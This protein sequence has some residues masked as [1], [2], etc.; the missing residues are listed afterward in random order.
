MQ[1]HNVLQYLF[2]MTYYNWNPLYTIGL[3]S[4]SLGT[5]TSIILLKVCGKN[6]ENNEN[7]VRFLSIEHN[8]GS[9][10]SILTEFKEESR[11]D[12]GQMKFILNLQTEENEVLKKNLSNLYDKYK[13]IEQCLD[14]E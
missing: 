12:I 3:F 4:V 10:S 5:L 8:I 1:A 13:K 11:K 6:N 2:N 14:S 9:I 7:N